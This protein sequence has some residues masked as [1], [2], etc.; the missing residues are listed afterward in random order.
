MLWLIITTYVTFD[1]S[2]VEHQLILLICFR[3]AS[4]RRHTVHHRSPGPFHVP[5]P[6]PSPVRHASG[7][8][9]SPVRHTSGPLLLVEE[10]AP[11][12][13]PVPASRIIPSAPIYGRYDPPIAQQEHPLPYNFP[14]QPN[15]LAT[16]SVQPS[17]DVS[18]GILPCDATSH[19][20]APP[21]TLAHGA[22]APTY[23]RQP[24]PVG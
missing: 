16:H 10:L 13:Y 5:G 11:A 9:P 12:P 20:M 22:H 6:P 17:S 15:H 19:M 21:N 23:T 3:S 8:P 2:V 18:Y 24:P 7:P 14:T 1:H 4:E